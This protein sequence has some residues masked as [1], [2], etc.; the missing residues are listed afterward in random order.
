MD[1]KTIGTEINSR[2]RLRERVTAMKDSN[3]RTY[4]RVVKL[5]SRKFNLDIGLP[6]RVVNEPRAIAMPR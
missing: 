3:L 4:A 2:P 5:K 1:G 6:W